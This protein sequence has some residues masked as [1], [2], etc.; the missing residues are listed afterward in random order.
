[1]VLNFFDF[2]QI[3]FNTILCINNGEQWTIIL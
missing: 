2:A 1:M 3:I